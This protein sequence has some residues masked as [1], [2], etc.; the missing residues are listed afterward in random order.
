MNSE[1]RNS[2]SP[3]SIANGMPCGQAGRPSRAGRSKA[4]FAS[5]SHLRTAVRTVAA[6]KAGDDF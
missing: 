2:I 5:N 3:T 1:A 4:G 6:G